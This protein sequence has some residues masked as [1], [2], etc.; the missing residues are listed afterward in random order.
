MITSVNMQVH[1]H[2]ESQ[3]LVWYGRMDIH[4]TCSMNF[5]LSIFLPLCKYEQTSGTRQRLDLY[6]IAI[7]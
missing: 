3:I 7:I 5:Q 6:S 4:A 2:V 1:Y